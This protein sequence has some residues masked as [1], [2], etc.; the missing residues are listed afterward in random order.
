MSAVS[1]KCEVRQS[2]A[3][4]FTLI[5]LLVVIAII[6]ILAGLLLPALASAKFKAKVTNCTS[7][8]KQWGLTANMYS[9][10][11]NSSFPSWS[12]YNAGGNPTDVASNFVDLIAPY[13]M[14]IPMYFCPVRTLD[15]QAGQSQ[16]QSMYHRPMMTIDDL[17]T[18]VWK[19]RSNNGN[20]SK[21][22]HCW[23]VQR[24]SNLVPGGMFPTTNSGATPTGQLSWPLKDTD[25]SASSQPIISDLAE[26]SPASTNVS[27]IQQGQTGSGSSY[28]VGNAHFMNNTLSSINVGY[29]DGHVELHN[30]S[31][32][33]WQYTGNSGGQ[34][35]FY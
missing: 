35:Y 28:Q 4:A 32:I 9:G 31:K 25:Y 33:Q 15:Y 8:F 24:P 34:S 10:D 19:I 21:L 22:E 30:A 13:G 5:E 17:N 14:T 1:C 3:K 18:W 2:P 23:W 6:A 7:N 11:N 26:V 29:G 20:F 12:A 27:A 16:F